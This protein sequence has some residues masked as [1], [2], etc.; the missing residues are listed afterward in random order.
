MRPSRHKI[1]YS[2][3]LAATT[4]G[5]RLIMSEQVRTPEPELPRD[6]GDEIAR[7]LPDQVAKVRKTFELFRQ[8]MASVASASA[9][10]KAIVRDESQ[11]DEPDPD[12][13]P[14]RP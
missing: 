7:Q 13:W 6:E 1:R 2:R 10:E 4:A 5:S 3:E 12:T 8:K 9:R 14:D 11:L